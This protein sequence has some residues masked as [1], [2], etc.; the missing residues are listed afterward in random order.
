MLKL[1]IVFYFTMVLLLSEGYNNLS[2]YDSNEFEICSSCFEVC[3]IHSE[4]FNNHSEACNS[5][6]EVFNSHSEARFRAFYFFLSSILLD[7]AQKIIV[8]SLSL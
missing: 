6:S 3:N 5:D 7:G 1:I 4:A 2:E 8:V